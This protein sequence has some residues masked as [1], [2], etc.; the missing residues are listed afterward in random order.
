[1]KQKHLPPPLLEQIA[2]K[3][4]EARETPPSTR[5]HPINETNSKVEGP[6]FMNNF[7][8]DQRKKT[9]ELLSHW[10]D[11]IFNTILF[12][13]FQTIQKI[14]KGS[15]LQTSFLFFPTNDSS[16]P[17]SVA[18]IVAG[19]THCTP[20]REKQRPKSP[21]LGAMEKNVIY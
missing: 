16:Q 1:M 2:V 8:S 15:T 20:K 19:S 9:K 3:H 14:H 5:T 18:L 13:A 21:S 17:K 12:L 10:I 6:S 4:G 11:V 7:V